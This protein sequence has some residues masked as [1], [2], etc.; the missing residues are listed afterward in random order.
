VSFIEDWHSGT[1]VYGYWCDAPTALSIEMACQRGFDWICIDLEHGT[2]E[3]AD[4]V[5]IN[6]AAA[7]SGTAVIVRVPWNE[8][9]VIMRALDAGSA[10]VI[11]PMVNTP[12]DAVRAAGA[13]RYAPQGYRSWGYV[14]ADPKAQFSL[15]AANMSVVCVVMIETVEAVQNIDEI[16]AVPGVDGAYI[17]RNDLAISAGLSLDNIRADPEQ[18]RYRDLIIDACRRHHVVCGMSSYSDTAE[19]SELGVTMLT[20]TGDRR[21]L[22]R[23][24]AELDAVKKV[25]GAT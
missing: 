3:P 17:G 13:C 20:V 1:P 25:A 8:P 7:V 4:L 15:A 21:L 5:P 19:L 16:L 2:A 12:E 10:G 11:V 18:I 6:H 22:A 23:S 24:A 14:K 9:G